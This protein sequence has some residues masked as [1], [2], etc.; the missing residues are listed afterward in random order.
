MILQLDCTNVQMAPCIADYIGPTKDFMHPC[1]MKEWDLTK[2]SSEEMK[3]M[4]NLI[5]LMKFY[6]FLH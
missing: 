4:V 1:T 3:I 5:V 6:L 2:P